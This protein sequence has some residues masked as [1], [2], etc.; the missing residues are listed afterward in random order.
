MSS[1]FIPEMKLYLLLKT[2][3]HTIM[4]TFLPTLLHVSSIKLMLY[5]IS[6]IKIMGSPD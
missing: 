1:F 5:K 4:V 6:L 2:L 3:S